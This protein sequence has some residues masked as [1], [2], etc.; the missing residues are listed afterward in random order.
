MRSTTENKIKYT[1][2]FLYDIVDR[3]NLGNK[4]MTPFTKLFWEFICRNQDADGQELSF[5]VMDTLKIKKNI[6]FRESLTNSNFK[7]MTGVELADYNKIFEAGRKIND[8]NRELNKR[9]WVKQFENEEDIFLHIYKVYT[10]H[11]V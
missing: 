10:G 7:E 1:T 8:K 5:R 4:K 3:H 11:P 2:D 9:N 6:K